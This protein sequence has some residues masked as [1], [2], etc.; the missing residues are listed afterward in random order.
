MSKGIS[1][2]DAGQFEDYVE[3][4]MEKT[5]VP[6]VGVGISVEGHLEYFKGFGVSDI[7]RNQPVAEDTVFGLASV[8]KSFTALAINQLVEKGKICLFHPVKRYLP[9]FKLP[10]SGQEGKITIHN[11][12]T[13]TSGIPP[14]PSLGYVNALSIPLDELLKRPGASGAASWKMSMDDASANASQAKSKDNISGGPEIRTNRDLLEFI[15]TYNFKLLG[16]PGQYVS[17]SNDC[18]SLL[19]EVIERVSGTSYERYLR[20]HVWDPLGM[21]H[22]FIDVRRLYDFERVQSLY[23]KNDNGEI[24]KAQW[25]HR[26]AFVS[27]GSI[28]SSVRDL[29]RYM[30][31][32][33]NGGTANGKKVCEKVTV[34]RMITP[35]YPLEDG[36]CYSYGFVVRPA[37]TD[38]TTLIHHGGNIVGVASYIGFIPE[39]KMSFAVLSNL[40]GFPAD[41]VFFAAVNLA[42]GLPLQYQE[43]NMPTVEVP[44][45]HLQKF[46]GRYVSGEGM[47]VTFVLEEQHLFAVLAENKKNKMYPVRPTGLNSVCIDRDGQDTPVFFLFEP[48]GNVWAI[49]YGLRLVRKVQ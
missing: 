40:S 4:L 9:E 23:Y 22:T 39:K 49:R 8:T 1:R 13:H 18:Y 26:D 10:V 5:K 7:E 45:E 27:S 46:A 14:L 21:D 19:G 48:Q 29:L 41:K 16:E 11:F 3:E 33:L 20:E 24:V 31:I 42:L 12:L 47:E 38:D 44:E 30:D 37:Y 2:F 36:T 35:Y 17:Y 6:G 25:K 34:D 15:A 28:K 43:L 32:Y